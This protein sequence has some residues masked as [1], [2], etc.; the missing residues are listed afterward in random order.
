LHKKASKPTQLLGVLA[1]AAAAVGAASA[2][3]AISISPVPLFVN[4]SVAP[5]A[6]LV[7]G[8]DHAT[9]RS[10]EIDRLPG[11]AAAADD[12]RPRMKS[13]IPCQVAYPEIRSNIRDARPIRE[14]R[15][16]M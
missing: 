7:M 11:S 16:K 3:A 6:L 10:F 8:R 5:L 12:D 13:R 1:L 2:S 14:L 4:Q 15:P 9:R